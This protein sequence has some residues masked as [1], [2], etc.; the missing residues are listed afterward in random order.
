MYPNSINQ[1]VGNLHDVKQV[2]TVYSHYNNVFVRMYF[3]ELYLRKRI[4]F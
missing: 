4:A 3:I 2:F 1:K